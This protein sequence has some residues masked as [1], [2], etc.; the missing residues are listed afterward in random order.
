MPVITDGGMKTGGDIA[1][2]IA[3]GADAVMLG[4]TVAAAREAPAPGISWGMATMSADLPRGTRIDV[5]V[6]GS[7]REILVGPAHRD[8]G[9]MNLVGALKLSMGSLGAR[10][11]RQMQQVEMMIAPSLPSEGKSL[12]RAQGVG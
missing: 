11:L 9:T 3:A 1:K 12:Q 5:G 8:D 6:S 4:S 7:L 2:A 10:N